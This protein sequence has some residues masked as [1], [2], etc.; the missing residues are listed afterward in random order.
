LYDIFE[1]PSEDGDSEDVFF[2]IVD[3][4]NLLP[5]IIENFIGKCC[6]VLL[7]TVVISV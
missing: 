3:T 1:P 7:V 6:A 5:K 2:I 4:K